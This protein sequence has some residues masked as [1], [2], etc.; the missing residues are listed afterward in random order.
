MKDVGS[1]VEENSPAG[2]LN[3][4]RLKI[5]YQCSGELPQSASRRSLPL[6]VRAFGNLHLPWLFEIVRI[7]PQMKNTFPL[8]QHITIAQ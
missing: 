5:F 6:L 2:E 8:R 3:L 4:Q 1:M 7:P